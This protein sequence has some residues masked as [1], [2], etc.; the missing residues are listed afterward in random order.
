MA[1]DVNK[2]LDRGKRYL[3]KNKLRDAVAEY[4]AV[5]EANPLHQEALQSLADIYTRLNEPARAAHYY[6]LQF[7]RLVE[8]GDAGKASALYSRFLKTVP[9]PPERLARYGLLLQRHNKASE[10]IEVYVVAAGRFREQQ[11]PFEALQ[12]LE[13]I[14]LLDPENPARHL[15][16][17]ESAEGLANA[18]VASRAYLRAGQLILAAGDLIRALDFLAHAH[19][20][21]PADRSAALFYATAC[22]RLGDAAQA[23]ALLEP[24]SPNE[25]DSAFHAAFGEALLRTGQLDRARVALEAYYR[26]KPDSFGMLFELADAYFKASAE[27]KAVAVLSQTKEWMR[28]V[29]RE[30]EFAA[31]MDRLGQAYPASLELADFAARFY[32]E[33]NRETKYFDSLVRLFDLFLAG[34]KLREACETLDRLIDID[35]YDYRNHERITQLEGKADPAYLRSVVAR[36]AKAATVIA[37]TE[38]LGGAAAEDHGTV[39]PASEEAR[40]RQAL[41]DLIVQVEIFLQYA[42]QAKAIERLERIAEMFPGEEE[43]NERLRA[44]YERANW[45]PKGV[46]PKPALPPTAEPPAPRAMGY[47]AETHRDLAAIAEITRLMYRQATPR[48]VVATAVHE[49]G[50]YL[51]ATRCLVAVGLAGEVQMTAEFSVPGVDPAGAARSAAALSHLSLVTPDALGGIELRSSAVPALREL[52]LQTALG[53]KLTDKE[54]QTHAGLLL[55]GDASARAW[56]PNESF[57]LQSI[58]DQLVLCVNHTRLRSLVRTLNVADEKTGLLS[59]GA[60]LDCLLTETNR[61]KLQGTPLSLVIL[62]IDRGPDLLREHGDPALESYIE[63][64]ARGL[65]SLVRQGDLAVKYTSW[66]IGFVLPDTTVENARTLAEKLRQAAAAIQPGWGKTPPTLSAV[67]AE[68]SRRPSDE[69]EDRVTEWINRSESGLDEVRHRGGDAVVAVAT[70]SE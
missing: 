23:V 9:Q 13:K 30:N 40:A 62:Q 17:A 1:V 52:G 47:S 21:A 33:M 67:V 57:F 44:L 22:L 29:R 31:Q 49:I 32:E 36:A 26:Q 41:D 55:A 11:Q 48:E 61:A 42:L 10:A 50:K 25:N 5:V 69:V 7:D 3:E 60:Y 15:E 18:E 34:G 19:R 24:F 43:R 35:P 4:E 37:R 70:P 6:A 39:S 27:A 64:L 59:R 53:A 51:G 12:C 68:I 45:W 66:S 56:K 20:L 63:Q 14:T 2:H 28:G 38:D 8:A 65:R 58:G 46:T 16:L 54:T